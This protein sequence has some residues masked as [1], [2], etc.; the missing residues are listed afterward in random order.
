MEQNEKPYYANKSAPKSFVIRVIRRA[1]INM[2]TP[3]CFT[4]RH[5]DTSLIQKNLFHAGKTS[6]LISLWTDYNY[7]TNNSNCQ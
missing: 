2:T 7:W 3:S 6:I 4:K 5:I 1:L